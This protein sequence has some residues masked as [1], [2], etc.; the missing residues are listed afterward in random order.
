M[1]GPNKRGRLAAALVASLALA[2]IFVA[3]APAGHTTTT[4]FLITPTRFD[5]GDV[6]VGQTSPEQRVTVTNVTSAPITVSGAGGG[7]GQF[8]GVQNCQG[9]TLAPGE[10]CTFFYAFTPAAPGPVTGSTSG[11]LNGQPFAFD[12][13]GNG[14]GPEFLVTPTRFDFGPVAL[15]STSPDQTATITNTGLAPVTVDGAGGGAGEFGGV[16]NCQGRTLAVGESCGFS[17]AF[18]PG[19]TGP[20]TGSTS[21]TLNGQPFAFDFA[22]VGEGPKFRISPTRFDF[23]DVQVGTTSPD[24]KATVTNIG[25]GPVTVNGAGGGAGDFGGVQNC[26]GRTLAVGE[27]CTFF[28]AFTPSAAGPATGSTS[29]TLNGQP[30]SFHFHGNGVAPRFLVSPTRLDFGEVP[31]GTTSPEQDVTVTNVGLA[32]VTVNGA[33]GGAGQF[34]GVQNCQGRTL[35]V[36]ES[37]TFSYAFT[38]LGAGPATGSTSGTLNGQ[39]FALDFSGTGIPTGTAPQGPFLIS[40]TR[41]DFGDV[42][43]GT[44]SA[45]QEVTVTNVTAGPITVSGAG[46]GAGE[47]GGVQNCQGRTLASGES[48]T[49]FYA[50]T[51]SAAGPATGNTSGTLNGQL[52]EFD[53]TGTAVAPKFRVSPT[54]FDFADVQLGTTSPDQ[55]VTVTN[56]GLAPVTVNGAG[57]GAGDFGGVQNCQGRTLAVGESCTFS[58]AFTPSAAGPATGSTSGTLNGQPFAFDFSGNGVGPRFR[59]SPTRFDFG[60]VQIG[61]TSAEQEVTVTNVGL[62]PVTVNGAG[63]GAGDFGGVQNCQ[64]RTLAVGES[65]TFFYAFTPSTTGPASGSTSGTLNGQPFAFDFRGVGVGPKFLITPTRFDFGEVVV[66]TTSPEQEVTVTNVGLAP[67]TVNGA[68]GGAGDF[69]GVQNCQGRTLAVGE[70]CT[71]SYAFT[72]TTTGPATGSTSG[73]LNGQPFAFDFRGIGMPVSDSTPP[74]IAPSVAPPEPDGTNG[75]YRSSPTVSFA[76]SDPESPVQT[77]GCDSVVVST[78][79]DPSGRTFTCIATS[80]GGTSTKSL[81]IKRDATPP[82]V[83]CGATPTFVLGA[84]GVVTATVSDTSSGALSASVTAAADT[85]SPGAHSAEITGADRAGNATTVSCPYFVGVELSFLQPLKDSL[86]PG[87]SLNVRL[88]LGDASGLPI[89]DTVAQPLAD[90]CAVRISLAGITECAA[91]IADDDAFQARVATSSSLPPGTYSLEVRVVVDG[92]LAAAGS[93]AIAVG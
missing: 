40:P 17:Y 42:Q 66:G 1:V 16:Q 76:V 85:S 83:T 25:L 36:G 18:T 58:Y 38:P 31:V 21:G 43:V 87:Q 19:T 15:G 39:P 68:G 79:T 33:G 74:V 37:C 77:S 12:F 53:F 49:F 65:C 89:A 51:P 80:A 60:K 46:G 72:P 22:G 3:A 27:S 70:S 20:A 5:F 91:Y 34:G 32:P 75:W 7:A 90:A 24:Q 30:F 13:R 45:E 92:Q 41:F 29:G 9:R 14:V 54:R 59:I 26:Q 84:N 82:T 62:A 78:D 2:G 4:I 44:T 86:K 61:T 93:R 69:G 52:F 73:T 28:Y 47:F 81:T 57:G 63:G 88:A 35:A 55:E 71:F 23:G 8:G 64:G 56:V 11:T 67:V 6:A 48:C 10:S 50:F